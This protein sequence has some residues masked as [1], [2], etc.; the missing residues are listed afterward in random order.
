MATSEFATQRTIRDA[1]AKEI[2]EDY[3]AALD[4]YSGI[5]HVVPFSFGAIEAGH[6]LHRLSQF[7]GRETPEPFWL[8]PT[9]KLLG[10]NTRLPDVYLL[11][12]VAWPVCAVLL[13][14]VLLTRVRRP[15]IA[16]LSL[17]LMAIAIAGSVVQLVWYGSISLPSAAQTARGLMRVTPNVY[18]ASYLLLVVT[19]LMTLTGTAKRQNPNIAKHEELWDGID[20][21][22]QQDHDGFTNRMG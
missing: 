9:K 3:D 21:A 8:A 13:F 15:A 11:P 12:L 22:R 14:V 7:Q 4:M 1:R 16:F 17:L 18:Y 6:S 20:L 10:L 5:L 19:A 2:S